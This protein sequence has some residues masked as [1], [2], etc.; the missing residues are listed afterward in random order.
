MAYARIENGTVSFPPHNDGNRINVHLDPE[1]LAEHGYVDMTEEEIAQ[2]AVPGVPVQSIFT[3]LQIRRAMRALEM[4]PVLDAILAGNATFAADW[5]DAQEIDL[6][7]PVF[8][9]AIAAAGITEEQI[10][11]IKT[12]ILE[13]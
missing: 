3:K 12:K 1:W 2:Y 6:T 11:A 8:A 7:D 5:A 13:G 9:S 4:E 10:A